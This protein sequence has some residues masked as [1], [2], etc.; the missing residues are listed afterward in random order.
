MKGSLVARRLIF[1][2]AF[3]M[4][5]ALTACVRPLHEDEETP[6]PEVPALTTPS[7][8]A[9]LTTPG[10][11]GET[12]PPGA[13]PA[14]GQQ[15]AAPGEATPLPTEETVT[16]GQVTYM[17]QAGD[18]VT[19]I[20][21]QYN[22]SPEALASANGLAVDSPLT[23]GQELIIPLGGETAQ[24]APTAEPEQPAVESPTGEQVY[25]VQPGDNL[26]RIGL[27]YGF[28]VAELAAYNGIVNPD[29][30]TVGQE[31][32]IPPK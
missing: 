15:P 22:V 14:E 21:Q 17:V 16:S 20:A 29:Y 24:P 31:I 2:F 23:V 4:A 9:E 11:P 26:Y 7:G 30:L 1:V 18:T 25:V 8:P 13:T 27:R 12:V 3:L 28:T 32:R 19:G 5:L 6:T 10:A